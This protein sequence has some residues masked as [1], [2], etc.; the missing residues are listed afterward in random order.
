MYNHGLSEKCTLSSLFL[1]FFD[2]VVLILF[3]R[4]LVCDENQF[5]FESE[6]STVMCTWAAVEIINYFTSRGTPV[7]AC[8]LDYR[9]S[10]DLVNHVK[11]F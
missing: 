11:M 5:E 1:I 3:D 2:W 7:Y 9:K 8:L 10:F 4:E 6:R